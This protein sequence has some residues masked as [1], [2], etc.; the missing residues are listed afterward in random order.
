MESTSLDF[1]AF[2]FII[3]L[4]AVVNGLGIVRWLV[5]FS[6]YLR[7]R[8]SSDIQHYWVFSLLAGYQFLLHILMW[9]ILWGVRDIGN[10]NFLTYLYL[11][12]GPVLLFLGTSLLTPS[13]EG[14]EVDVR[15]HFSEVR[16]TYSTVLVLVWSWTIVAGPVLRGGF[17]PTVPLLALLLTMAVALRA[18][19]NPKVHGI[20][21]VANWLLLVAFVALY[22]MQLGGIGSQSA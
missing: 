3:T 9:W 15:S 20:V 21:V 6:E 17:A 11:L 1:R 8:Q 10:F 4:V 22:G 19:A 14:D 13:I 5:A 16:P 18:S 12:T 2:A 7:Q